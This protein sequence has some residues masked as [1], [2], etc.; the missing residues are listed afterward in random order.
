MNYLLIDDTRHE[1]MRSKTAGILGFG[2]GDCTF[3]SKDI[4]EEKIP[5]LNTKQALSA[6]VDAE[7][8]WL[9][10][11]AFAERANTQFQVTR[12]RFD[13]YFTTHQRC[14]FAHWSIACSCNSV[15]EAQ[16]QQTISARLNGIEVGGQISGLSCQ[17]VEATND[18]SLFDQR[19]KRYFDAS[20]IR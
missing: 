19:R 14:D 1:P 20:Y 4:R 11:S 7:N 18:G 13:R 15:A 10:K 8:C 12:F 2:D 6:N 16:G 3:P 5:R 17:S 9:V